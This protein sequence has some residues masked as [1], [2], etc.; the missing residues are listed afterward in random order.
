MMGIV[1]LGKTLAQEIT[2]VIVVRICGVSLRG[3]TDYPD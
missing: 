1:P 3:D 2:I